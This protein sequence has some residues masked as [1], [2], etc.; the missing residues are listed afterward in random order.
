MQNND[1]HH[2]GAN[3]IASSRNPSAEQ[4][5][6]ASSEIKRNAQIGALLE[7]W[8]R[9]VP[10]VQNPLALDVDVDVVVVVDCVVVVVVDC[11]NVV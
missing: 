6:E 5:L 1:D 4:Q 8:S 2:L 10:D 9:I 3:I 7:A 11:V